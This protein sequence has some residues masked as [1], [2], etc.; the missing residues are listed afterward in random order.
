MVE[1][2]TPYSNPARKSAK[3]PCAIRDF[4]TFPRGLF[5]NKNVKSMVKS[6]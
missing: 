2:A 6:P 3:K 5:L 1:V 4:S